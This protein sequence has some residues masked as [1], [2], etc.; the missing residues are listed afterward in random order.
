[1]GWEP[2]GDDRVWL[3]LTFCFVVAAEFLEHLD[4]LEPIESGQ[5]VDIDFPAHMLFGEKPLAYVDAKSEF[6]AQTIQAIKI[7]LIMTFVHLA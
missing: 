1:M 7:N 6:L 4:I 2:L 5:I 3:V